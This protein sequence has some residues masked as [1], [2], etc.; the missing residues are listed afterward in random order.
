LLI[1]FKP[2]TVFVSATPATQVH[3]ARLTVTFFYFL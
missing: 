2:V 3:V 1:P